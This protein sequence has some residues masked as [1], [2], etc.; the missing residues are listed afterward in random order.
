MQRLNIRDRAVL[1][2]EDLISLGIGCRTK[3][4]FM[5]KAGEFPQPIKIWVTVINGSLLK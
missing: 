4:Y 2:T 3:I 5:V 1:S